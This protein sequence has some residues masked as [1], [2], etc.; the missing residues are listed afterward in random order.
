[1]ENYR[2]CY[3]LNYTLYSLSSSYINHV[4]LWS[5]M[6]VC[7]FVCFVFIERSAFFFW[8]SPPFSK[9]NCKDP[10]KFLPGS[11]FLQGANIWGSI[12]SFGIDSCFPI[13]IFF[14]FWTASI[15]NELLYL[16]EDLVLMRKRILGKLKL[17]EEY[18][19]YLCIHLNVVHHPCTS[20]AWSGLLRWDVA[21]TFFFLFFFFFFFLLKW[22]FLLC[23]ICWYQAR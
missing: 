10:C 22:L 17:H 1:M 11:L 14:W 19:S 20:I 15:D 7:F 9:T 21:E 23:R 12:F 6:L 16:P 8:P 18:K 5:Q 13:H 2:F 3:G 4:Y